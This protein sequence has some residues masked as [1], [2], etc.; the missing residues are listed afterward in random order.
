[1]SR[2]N[3]CR[4]TSK[5]TAQRNIK[6]RRNNNWFADSVPGESSSPSSGCS[7]MIGGIASD[8]K[9]FATAAELDKHW[10]RTH[11]YRSHRVRRVIHGEVPAERPQTYAVVRQLKPGVRYRLYFDAPA[12]LPDS[13]APEHV[14]HAIFDLTQK[15]Y[16]GRSIPGYE[17]SERIR[18][19]AAGAN[20]SDSSSDE[21]HGGHRAERI[22]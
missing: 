5:T 15:Y 14:A 12:A 10:F 11:P 17:L 4:S 16:G 20:T 7:V 19:Y 3:A 21:P 1:M 9:A 2:N 6:R 13:E 22:K 18:A 8:P